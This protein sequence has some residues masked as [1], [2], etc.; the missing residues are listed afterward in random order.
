MKEI[1][2][3]SRLEL[4]AHICT[5]LQKYGIE[6]TLTGGS[7]VSIYSEN[8]YL[9]WDLDFIESITTKRKFLADCLKEIGFYEENRKIKKQTYLS[10]F[11][12]DL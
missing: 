8:Q 1:K 2:E 5:H 7:C 12:Q 3:M 10:N 4:A 6:I 11:H 9:S